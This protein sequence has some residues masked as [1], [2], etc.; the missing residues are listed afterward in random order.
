MLFMIRSIPLLI[1][2]SCSISGLGPDVKNSKIMVPDITGIT[3]IAGKSVI[4][5]QVDE[6]KTAVAYRFKDGRIAVGTGK[7]SMWSTDNGK[8][9]IPGPETKI[10]KNVL[11]LGDGEAIAFEF[12]TY[13]RPDGKFDGALLRSTD[14]WNTIVSEKIIVDIPNASF[15]VTGSGSRRNGFMFHHGSLKLSNGDLL[16]TMYGNYNGDTEL[17]DAYPPELGQ[18]KYH[19]IVVRSHDGGRTWGEPVHIAYNKMLGRGIPDDHD[20]LGKSIPANRH[21]VLSVVPAVTM[22]GFRESDL[23]QATNGDLVCIMRSGGRNIESTAPHFPTPLYCSISKDEGRSWSVPKQV[24]DRGIS[25]NLL[26]MSNGIIVCTYG[27]PGNWLIFSDDNGHSWKGAFQFGNTGATNYV[28]EVGPNLIQVYHEVG[29]G[30]S[31]DL[32]ASFFTVK[33]S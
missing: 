21:S 23:V 27:R 31:C 15:T 2:F 32:W 17:C 5:P 10:G 33:P 18:R 3:V 12:N 22:E 25:P 30:E 8:S 20:M 19:T 9:W 13:L 6:V 26:T 14:N 4:I 29:D 11:D 16:S 28:E 1:L 7:N 24:A